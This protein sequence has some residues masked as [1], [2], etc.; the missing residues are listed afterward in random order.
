MLAPFSLKKT[1]P[2]DLSRSHS[3]EELLWPKSTRVVLLQPRKVS[4]F[5]EMQH[6]RMDIQNLL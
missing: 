3:S 1:A 6:G 2:F 5:I 4:S